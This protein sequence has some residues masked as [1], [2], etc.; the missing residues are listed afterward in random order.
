MADRVKIG[1][2]GCGAIA[3]QVHI[4]LLAKRTDVS[5]VALAESDPHTL[6]AVRAR[7]PSARAYGSLYELLAEPPDA[8]IV[9]LPTAAH[10]EAATAVL[11]AG[12]DL[13]LEKPLGTEVTEALALLDAWRTS[14]RIGM[15]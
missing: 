8:V 9:A 6:V 15:M 1:I 13:Y 2:A 12:C 7:V 4:P 10:A 11:E 3:R 5:I 14:G